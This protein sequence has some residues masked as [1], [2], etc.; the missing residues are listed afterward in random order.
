V[1]KIIMLPPEQQ[2]EYRLQEEG[3]A[4]PNINLEKPLQTAINTSMTK[5]KIKKILFPFALIL[6]IFIIYNFF[7]WYSKAKSESSAKQEQEAAAKSQQ[8]VAVPQLEPTSVSPTLEAKTPRIV[9]VTPQPTAANE[10]VAQKLDLLAQKTLSHEEKLTDLSSSL[11]RT[12]TAVVGLS[13]QID[14]V[15]TDVQSLSSQFK[16]HTVVKK[17]IIKSKVAQVTYNIKAIVP[18][19]VWL[20]SSDGQ[21]VSLRE[22]DKLANYGTVE[23]ISPRQGLVVTSSGMVIQYGINDF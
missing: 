4:N 15:S 6:A 3:N 13:K 18:G 23:T 19:R 16:K 9:D 7:T 17:K 12:Q 21:T 22:G 1:R 20:E 14:N 11:E 8:S 10:E 5:A 2:G